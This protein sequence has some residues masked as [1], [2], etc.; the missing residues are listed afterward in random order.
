MLW[1][2]VR[3]GITIM[4]HVTNILYLSGTH[5]VTVLTVNWAPNPFCK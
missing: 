1:L 4:S 2:E 3:Y 5:V